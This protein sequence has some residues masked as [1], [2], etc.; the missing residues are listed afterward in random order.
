MKIANR[1]CIILCLITIGTM[2]AVSQAYAE[3]TVSNSDI[4]LLRSDIR[5]QKAALVT[6]RMHFTNREADVFWPIYRKYEVELAAIND[7]KIFLLKDYVS[8]YDT[9]NDDQ[10]KQL[11]QGVLEV[12]QATVDLTGATAYRF[13]AFSKTWSSVGTH[14]IK[15]VSMGTPVVRVDGTAIGTGGAP[16]T[17]AGSTRGARPSQR[18]PRT[19]GSSTRSPSVSARLP[20]SFP[21]TTASTDW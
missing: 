4:E 17:T 11:A 20:R 7:R 8:R 6:D 3:E 18:P 1:P 14:T 19:H 13:V 2:I 15:V 9:M 5:T 16:S 21:A 12:D 10:A